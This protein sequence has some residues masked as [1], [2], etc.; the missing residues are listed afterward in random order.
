MHKA[1]NDE[2]DL[3]SSLHLDDDKSV[4]SGYSLRGS[5][6]HHASR[7]T[8]P[9]YCPD[10]RDF[11]LNRTDMSEIQEPSV[12]DSNIAIHAPEDTLAGELK[13]LDAVTEEVDPNLIDVRHDIDHIADSSKKNTVSSSHKPYMASGSSAGVESGQNNLLVSNFNYMPVDP[14]YFN[15]HHNRSK[16]AS[17]SQ[18]NRVLANNEIGVDNLRVR[19]FISGSRVSLH[20]YEN[21]PLNQL[22]N[23]SLND[24]T[25]SFNQIRRNDGGKAEY[26]APD[27][28]SEITDS[29]EG[30]PPKRDATIPCNSPDNA[31]TMRDGSLAVDSIS[32]VVSTEP[33]ESPYSAS[34]II[35][36]PSAAVSYRPSFLTNKLNVKNNA[37]KQSVE[38]IAS[39]SA[40]IGMQNS[41]P[42][43]STTNSNNIAGPS[44]PNRHT[45]ASLIDPHLGYTTQLSHDTI[46]TNV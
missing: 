10:E 32:Q 42:L 1:L 33:R 46:T 16:M 43:P 3:L 44:V 12:F 14:P 38:K 8:S 45:L 7:P 21:I 31:G 30:H 37:C 25:P 34:P 29:G 17:D 20:Q 2:W 41:F 4:R 5:L 19:N 15:A 11:G 18:L 27:T 40:S 23:S 22:K 26:V 36:Q 6:C 35:I 28:Q 39:S 9:E 24:N 13:P